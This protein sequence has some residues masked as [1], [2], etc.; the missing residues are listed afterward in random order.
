M[1]RSFPGTIAT[2]IDFSFVGVFVGE[3]FVARWEKKIWMPVSG[4]QIFSFEG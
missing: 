2:L 1:A 3:G 4:I